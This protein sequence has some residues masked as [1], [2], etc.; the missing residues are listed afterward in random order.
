MQLPPL[1]VRARQ[2][3]GIYLDIVITPQPQDPLGLMAWGLLTTTGTQDAD[4]IPFPAQRM[5]RNA[6]FASISCEQDHAGVSTLLKKFWATTNASHIKPIRFPCKTGRGGEHLG[7][8][9]QLHGLLKH[10]ICG[11]LRQNHSRTRPLIRCT[12]IRNRLSYSTVHIYFAFKKKRTHKMCRFH[13][14]ECN[15]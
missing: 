6:V 1:A 4:L 7:W 13:V 15:V 8:F 9:H 14:F 10:T 3:L 12:R 2:A 11:R 5:A